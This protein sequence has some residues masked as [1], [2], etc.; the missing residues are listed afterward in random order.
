VQLEPGVLGQ[1]RLD[2]G[3]VVG[4]VVVED[5]ID[6]QA[7]GTSRSIVGRNFKNSMWR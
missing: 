5:Q 3:V 6:L 1:P 4:G 2:V 7:L